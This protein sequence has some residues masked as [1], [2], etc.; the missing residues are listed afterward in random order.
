MVADE[1]AIYRGAGGG[2]GGELGSL[3]GMALGGDTGYAM[4]GG[5]SFLKYDFG[6]QVNAN[7]PGATLREGAGTQWDPHV[8]AAFQVCRHDF[9]SIC[10][11]GIGD[12]VHAA[13]ERAL[14][15]GG[16]ADNSSRLGSLPG[17]PG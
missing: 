12:S 7:L 6:V 15:A 10:Q 8:V 2:Y 16:E 11:R 4:A 13:V 9:Y 17:S 5:K 3:L 1:M 14:K